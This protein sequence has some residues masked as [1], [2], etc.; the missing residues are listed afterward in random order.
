MAKM[1][2]AASPLMADDEPRRGNPTARGHHFPIAST[3]RFFMS[4]PSQPPRIDRG[5][6]QG[7]PEG[8]A[9][10]NMPVVVTFIQPSALMVIWM[11]R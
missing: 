3:P 6:H 8:R 9:P 7:F 10:T 2:G 1:R 11:R 5:R 4:C